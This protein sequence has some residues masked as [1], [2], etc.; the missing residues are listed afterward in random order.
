MVP[1]H[2]KIVQARA[3]VST[4]TDS[5]TT[6]PV[7]PGIIIILVCVAEFTNTTLLQVLALILLILL[8]K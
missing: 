4:T 6:N 5:V 7:I 2:N 3:V 1:T 8:I